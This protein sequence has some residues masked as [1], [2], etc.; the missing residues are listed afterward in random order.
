[1]KLQHCHRSDPS[2]RQRHASKGLMRAD[3]L[4]WLAVFLGFIVTGCIVTSARTPA[5][6][7]YNA[8]VSIT[9]P[10]ANQSAPTGQ[11]ATFFVVPAATASLT[12][13]WSRPMAPSIKTQPISQSIPTGQR[14]TFYVAAS[15]TATLKY[16]WSKNGTAIA[17]A[18]SATYTIPAT[19]VADDGGRFTV[20]VSNSTGKVTSSIAILTVIAPGHLNAS[21]PSLSFGSVNVGGN[22]TV[23]VVLTNSGGSSV[24]ISSVSI[25]GPGF[26]VSGIPSGTILA[27]G[28]AATLNAAFTPAARGSATGSVT[29]NSNEVNPSTIISLT[30]SGIQSVEHSATFTWTT[31]AP[32]IA[33]YNVYQATVSGGPFTKLTSSL[34]TLTSYTD[35]TVKAGQTYY[36]AVTAVDSDNIESVHSNTVSAV[37]P[38]S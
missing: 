3:Q 31:S 30:G 37:I 35:A 2:P 36:Y 34:Y 7:T 6:S 8:P 23:G 18:R 20:T 29:I 22:S 24:T 11:K 16:N 15:G 27:G 19:V 13:R 33:G 14:A 1:M 12:S 9:T 26:S 10:P 28:Q 17:G 4:V 32:S 21:P 38:G 25:S 5:T